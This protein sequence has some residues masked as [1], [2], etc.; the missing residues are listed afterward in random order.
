MAVVMQGRDIISIHEL[1]GEEVNQILDTAGMLKMKNQVGEIY[2][3]LKGK[4]LGMIFQKAS[5]RTRISFE[6]AMWQLGL[7]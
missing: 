1:T 6:V 7:F 3:P 2:H 4:T 5:T